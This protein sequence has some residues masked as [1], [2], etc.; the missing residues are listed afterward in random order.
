MK[1]D[2]LV[3]VDLLAQIKFLLDGNYVKSREAK[4]FLNYIVDTCE[5]VFSKFGV[6]CKYF[7][8]F[9]I[10]DEV[11]YEIK[12]AVIKVRKY[13]SDPFFMFCPK[14][15]EERLF[16]FYVEEEHF[17]S[18]D[19]LF[20]EVHKNVENLAKKF[21]FKNVKHFLDFCLYVGFIYLSVNYDEKSEF[22]K[23]IRE[24]IP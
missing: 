4:K 6:S 17:L 21:S 2:F 20:F 1:C 22:I 15:L 10:S 8:N 3:N 7:N 23:G 19:E 14:E 16:E 5:Y 13:T 24:N 12:S 11:F 9:E 18:G